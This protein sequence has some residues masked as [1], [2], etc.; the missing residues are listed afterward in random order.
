MAWGLRSR[1]SAGHTA[2]SPEFQAPVAPHRS[3]ILSRHAPSSCTARLKLASRVMICATQPTPSRV[4]AMTTEAWP[5]SRACR[6]CLAEAWGAPACPGP[7]SPCVVSRPRGAG[8]QGKRERRHKKASVHARKALACHSTAQRTR[9]RP[10][11]LLLRRDAAAGFRRLP[12]PSAGALPPS[13]PRP[14]TSAPCGDW[15]GT[16]PGGGSGNASIGG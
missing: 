15:S 4:I 16:G 7:G 9:H 14:D 12:A 11:P 13:R 5:R 3:G 10:R 6:A 8:A 1:V 2:F